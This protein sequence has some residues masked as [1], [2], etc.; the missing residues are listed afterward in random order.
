MRTFRLLL[1]ESP[2]KLKT[3]LIKKQTQGK[4]LW[5][6]KELH[7]HLAKKS[8]IK[9]FEIKSRGRDFETQNKEIKQDLLMRSS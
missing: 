3:G 8:A 5:E 2:T 6:Q 9:P 1:Q 4:L 7:R